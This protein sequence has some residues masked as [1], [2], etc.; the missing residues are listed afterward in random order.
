MAVAMLAG[1]VSGAHEK[2]SWPWYTMLSAD[3]ACR[4]GAA[5]STVHRKTITDRQRLG[6]KLLSVHLVSG[7]IAS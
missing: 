6:R 1:A 2:C 7:K 3:P 5:A 4:R